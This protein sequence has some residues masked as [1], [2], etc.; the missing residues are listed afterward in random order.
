MGISA[1]RLTGEYSQDQ[2]SRGTEG[3]RGGQGENQSGDGVSTKVSPNT[4][5]SSAAAT[6][7]QSC[8][9]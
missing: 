8:P 7:L 2:H 3:S 6:A 9:D 1:Q 4:T 5:G